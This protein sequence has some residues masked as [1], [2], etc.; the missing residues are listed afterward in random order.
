[1]F[2]SP[3]PCSISTLAALQEA[4]HA[5][6]QQWFYMGFTALILV[7]LAIDLGILNRKAHAVS[8]RE[9]LGWTGV[10]I[11]CALCFAA[12]VHFIYAHHWLG[13][14]LD[15]PQGARQPPRTVE[16]PEATG[17]FLTSWLLEYAL[18]M[19]NIFVMALIFRYFKVPSMHQHRVLF[20]GILGAL[21]LR[22]L[23]IWAGSE[24]IEAFHWIEY[25]F[26]AFLV[27][28]GLKML[29][30]GD[31]QVDP[32]RNPIV[33]AARRLVRVSPQF[34]AERFFTRLDGRF[35]VTP[36]FLVLLV[37]ESTDVVFAVDSIP[38]I[39][40]VTRDPFIIFTSNIFAILGLRSLYFALA[41]LMGRFEHLKYALS[42]I[43]CF[44]GAKMIAMIWG[45]TL[46]PSI[47][48]AIIAASLA[49]GVAS[50][51]LFGKPEATDEASQES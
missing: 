22:G 24:L 16:G 11:T 31:A 20:W 9:A 21:V 44:I 8:L 45:F 32:D 29:K 6:S 17:L 41:A 38:A 23:M 12:A 43:L 25:V 5:A 14:G 48:L 50:S 1:V 3:A 19:D 40:G 26:G 28:T 13:F 7:L 35:A 33:K 37:V 2:T 27:Y 47:S 18:S 46:S 15:V 42:F 34:E 49:A 30:A 4:P 51:L 36:M 10:W 39:F